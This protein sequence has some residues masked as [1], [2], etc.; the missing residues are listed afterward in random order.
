M[1]EGNSGVI[2]AKQS[3]VLDPDIFRHYSKKGCEIFLLS[4][5]F[6]TQLIITHLK[7]CTAQIIML[8]SLFLYLLLLL[9]H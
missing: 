3:S 7:F 5:P 9:F 6:T 1:E 8:S 2:V 4:E